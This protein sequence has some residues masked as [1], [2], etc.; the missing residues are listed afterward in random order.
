[1]TDKQAEQLLAEVEAEQAKTMAALE[2]S[3]PSVASEGASV[4]TAAL[5]RAAAEAS[6][7]KPTLLERWFGRKEKDKS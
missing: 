3:G 1:M 5:D 7:H 4:D 2:A 6:K